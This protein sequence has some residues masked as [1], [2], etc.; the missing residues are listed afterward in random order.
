MT[1]LVL[2]IASA[3]LF[4]AMT[5]ALRLALLRSPDARVGA[6][7]TVLVAFA[8]ALPATPLG[9]GGTSGRD[10]V[11]FG[12]A[13]ALAPGVSQL[14]FSL[15]VRDS[16]AARTSVVVGGAPLVTVVLGLVLLD[17]PLHAGL[18]AGAVL[19]VVGGTALAWERLRPE[20]FRA[21]GLAWA[22]G[23]TLLFASRDTFV[24]WFSGETP[25]ASTAAAAATLAGG[26]LVLSLATARRPWRG[27][28]AFVPAGLCFGLSYVCLFEAYY[29]GRVTVVSP[30]VATESL[31]GVGLSALL[32][33]RSELVGRRL[34]AGALLIVA[35]GALIG[36]FR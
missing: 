23:A 13:G 26:A 22:V 1:V 21:V 18:V 33:G 34:V 5:V 17:E 20:S 2:A 4:G 14:L 12:L 11:L 7:V 6:A 10:L 29:R 19:I 9:S 35:G 28:G 30:L 31:W 15:A 3:A 32:I 16:G 8:V 27:V 36:A 25:V 24:R